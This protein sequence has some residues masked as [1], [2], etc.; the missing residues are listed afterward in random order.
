MGTS[1]EGVAVSKL[2][3]RVARHLGLSADA[4]YEPVE[5]WMRKYGDWARGYALDQ[6]IL[7]RKA[8]QE[9]GWKPQF[10]ADT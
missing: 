2:V 7:S 9:L 8:I 6:V 5:Y 3:S 10:K 4:I 1:E